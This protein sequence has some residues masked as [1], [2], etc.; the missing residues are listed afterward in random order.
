MPCGGTTI[1]LLEKLFT[2]M[3]IFHFILGKFGSMTLDMESFLPV[4]VI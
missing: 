4:A 3:G 2:H 1:F